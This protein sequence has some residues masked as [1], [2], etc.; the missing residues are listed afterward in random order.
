LRLMIVDDEQMTRE[1]LNRLIAWRQHGVDDVVLASDGE[2][3]LKIAEEY[4]PDIL[5]TD[6]KMPIIDGIAL[7]REFSERYPMCRPLFLS[8]YSDKEYLMSAIRLKAS[9]FIEKPI[10]PDEV[11]A[12][13]EAAVSE[14]L[15]EKQKKELETERFGALRQDFVRNLL[16]GNLAFAASFT[17]KLGIAC[18][19]TPWTAVSVRVS[20]AGKRERACLYLKKHAACNDAYACEA[21]GF[22]H[23]LIP[24]AAPSAHDMIAAAARE[25][26]ARLF[27]GT[28]NE[29]GGLREAS[30]ALACARIAAGS[31]FFFGIDSVFYPEIQSVQAD[32]PGMPSDPLSHPAETEAAIEK[33]CE[34]LKNAKN[35]AAAVDC[36]FGMAMELTN[37]VALY[38][39]STSPL[40]EDHG[41]LWKWIHQF[42]TLDSAQKA[43]IDA[44]R[45]LSSHACRCS[46]V[47]E[48]IRLVE[49]NLC[50]YDLSLTWIA[51]ALKLNP[52]YLCTLFREQTGETIV[53]HITGK[54]MEKAKTVLLESN[55]QIQEAAMRVGYADTVWFIKRFKRTYGMTPS[56][57][58]DRYGR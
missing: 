4:P 12:A 18:E 52:S 8:G 22:V 23:I 39:I 32:I 46:H 21:E 29:T 44:V 9:A 5:L 55:V 53:R 6:I 54:R 50:D 17:A 38:R 36:L 42:S 14:V 40:P 25:C 33:A 1:S 26:G 13:V 30:Y 43:L 41:K 58:R 2:M 20:D 3:A 51:G 37:C 45:D 47:R 56:E 34:A 28:A 57:F 15:S 7:A 10:D 24:G 48:A 16:F 19:P 31:A 27:L 49:E 11:T 35:I